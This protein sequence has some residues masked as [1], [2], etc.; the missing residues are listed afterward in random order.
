MLLVLGQ[1]DSGCT[2]ALRTLANQRGG[3]TRVDGDVTYGG[4]DHA[5]FAKYF[6]GEAVYNQEDD[7]HHPT[8]KVGQ[9]LSF[10]L[11]TKTPGRR[12][13]G[14]SVSNFKEDVITTL[15]KMF[16]MEHTRNTM[17]GGGAGVCG[18]FGGGRK[19]NSIA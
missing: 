2:T 9:I 17:A 16:N 11:D 10:A 1:P 12:V 14:M 4:I 3:Y 13:T 7:V 18:G 15:L 5:T 6:R 19:R 8:L